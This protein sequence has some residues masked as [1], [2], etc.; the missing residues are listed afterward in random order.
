[1]FIERYRQALIL[2]GKA[3]EEENGTELSLRPA[4]LCQYIGQNTVKQNLNISIQAAKM[5]AEA[6]D[7]VLLYGPPG[8]GK[9]TLAATIANEMEVNFRST[10]GPAIERAGD[11]AAILSSLEP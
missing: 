2:T 6:L 9:T 4:K 5:R 7:H 10:A 8:L 1:Q 11:L 3:I